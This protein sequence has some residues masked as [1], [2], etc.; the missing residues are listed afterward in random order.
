MLQGKFAKLA[1]LGVVVFIVILAVF[2]VFFPGGSAPEAAADSITIKPYYVEQLAEQNP[3]FRLPGGIPMGR[4]RAER[5]EVLFSDAGFTVLEIVLGDTVSD[6]E[7]ATVA[8]AT[9]KLKNNTDKTRGIM[10][11]SMNTEGEEYKISEFGISANG[12]KEFKVL[13]GSYLEEILASGLV[14]IEAAEE[15]IPLFDLVCTANCGPEHDRLKVFA[16]R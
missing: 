4:L 7:N 5:K 14:S 1:V 2:L 12:S 10:V 13:V 11:L 6:G 3:D 16:S 15:G 9:L 8:M